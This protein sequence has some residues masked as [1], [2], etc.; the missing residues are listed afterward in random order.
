MP[1]A[2]ELYSEYVKEL[3]T[4]ELSNSENYDK[5]ILQLSSAFLGLSVA[6]IKD[7]VDLK[8]ADFVSILYF[9]W[10]FFFLA[11]ICSV[12][13]F[14]TAQEANRAQQQYA[15]EYYMNNRAEYL[16]KRP[17]SQKITTFLNYISGLMFILGVL[18]LAIFIHANTPKENTP[19]A[20]DHTPSTNSSSSS[21]QIAKGANPPVMV[22]INN[23]SIPQTGT[24]PP[25][26][27]PITPTP[28]QP[29]KEK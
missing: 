17:F 21:V 1:N 19:M 5:S 20:Q 28:V 26:M 3:R 22:P 27:T 8:V 18:F 2:D 12:L 24:V 6:F 23:T 9:S 14:Q 7:I 4:R 13:S 16:N 11:I 29:T 10:T 15:Y 25:P